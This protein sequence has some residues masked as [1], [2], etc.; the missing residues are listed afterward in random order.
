VTAGPAKA[1]GAGTAVRAHGPIGLIGLA[2]LVG[3][4]DGIGGTGVP[5]ETDRDGRGPGTRGPAV[6]ERR[7]GR[8]EKGRGGDGAGRPAR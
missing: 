5:A 8:K 6:A 1:P 3:A 7:A 2:G 4:D